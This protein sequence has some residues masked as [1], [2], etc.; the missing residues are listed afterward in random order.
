MNSA[1]IAAK[2]VPGL[3]R[4]EA[5]GTDV[6]DYFI[7]MPAMSSGVSRLKRFL[8]FAGPGY[9]VAVG[10]MD[11]GN[12]A[13]SLSGGSFFGYSLLSVILVSNL[14]AML[15]QAAALRLGIA[16]GLNLAEA[17]RRAFGRRT[18]LMLWVGC[19]VAIIACNIAE[20]LGMAC[21]IGLL[22]HIPLALGV[23]IT[24]FDVML[25]MRLQRRGVRVFEA[26][27]IGLITLVAICFALQLWWLRPSLSAIVAGALPTLWRGAI[28]FGLV[29]VPVELRTAAREN[30]LPLHMLDSRDFAPVGY[31]R[32]NKQTGKEVDWNHIVKGYEYKK[33]E[34]VALTD[35]DFK[36]A[37]VKA[38]ETIEIDTFCDASEVSTIYLDKPYYLAPAKG[39]G[40]VYALLRQALAATDKVAVATFV[41]HQRKDQE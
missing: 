17:C 38:S 16:T 8:S 23:C 10:Y 22:F 41:M 2:L 4:P 31:H 37:N 19:E 24:A 11:P 33:G 29:Y 9:V 13:T 5:V 39:G 6:D 32:I 20:V 28:S 30:T 36:H 1:A 15:L 40:K 27:I 7:A 21:G 25:V 3:R 14:M 26:F 18:N 34:F 12:W 35:A